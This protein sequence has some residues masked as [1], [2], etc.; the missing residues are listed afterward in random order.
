MNLKNVKLNFK[1][2]NKN[3]NLI[4]YDL[5][6]GILYH[7]IYL[8]SNFLLNNTIYFKTLFVE[9]LFEVGILKIKK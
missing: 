4:I 2:T 6:F 9:Y 5:N 1:I 3:I 8:K 7:Q